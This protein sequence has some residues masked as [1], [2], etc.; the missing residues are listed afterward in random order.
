MVMYQPACDPED[1]QWLP[2]ANR[3]S[4]WL[5][6]TLVWADAKEQERSG[7]RVGETA[8]QI[9]SLALLPGCLPV[10]AAYI[11]IRCWLAPVIG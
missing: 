4:D 6:Y 11:F 2:K 1:D 9:R 8:A 5:A 3:T 7:S 10:G